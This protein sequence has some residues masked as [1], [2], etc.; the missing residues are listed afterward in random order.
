MNKFVRLGVSIIAVLW[1]TTGWAATIYKWKDDNGTVQYTAQP[2]SDRNYEKI[3]TSSGSSS[4]SDASTANQP[5]AEDS[6]PE[7]KAMNMPPE[8]RKDPERCAWARHNL[9]TLNTN[10][11]IKIQD[12][13]GEMRFLNQEEISEK[14]K[15]V[16]TAIEQSC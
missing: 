13:N 9:E 15:E 6:K 8:S 16:E 2:P 11:R 10:S 3:K 1:I 12:E 14:R 7:Q 4:R 5:A